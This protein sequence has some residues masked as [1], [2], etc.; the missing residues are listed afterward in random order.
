MRQRKC[1]FCIFFEFR[2]LFFRMKVFVLPPQAWLQIVDLKNQRWKRKMKI[3]FT[4]FKC[5]YSF[6]WKCKVERLG[7]I[8]LKK[9]RLAF[10]DGR[11]RGGH[12]RLKKMRSKKKN[13]K[14]KRR[15]MENPRWRILDG[16]SENKNGDEGF[17]FS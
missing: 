11:R 4:C 7:L 9:M 16:E 2:V 13:E 3:V 6:S 17:L 14:W 8:C 1:N 10:E 5:L 15:K 12:W